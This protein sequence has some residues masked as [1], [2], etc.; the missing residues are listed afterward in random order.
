M[1]DLRARIII[2]A[3]DQSRAG[4]N[5]AR[6]GLDNLRQQA[7]Q[8][9][10]ALIGV[11]GIS[12]GAGLIKQLIDTADEFKNLQASIKLSTTSEQEFNQAQ[13]ELFNISQRTGT[14]LR[15]NVNLF[16]RVSAA[17][18]DMGG[19]QE[20]ALNLVE[21]IG[22]SVSL[23]QTSAE[24]AAA[25]V[26]QFNQGLASGV[27][28][29]EEFNSVMENT[30]RLAQAIAD[31]LQST[32]GELRDM[33]KEGKLTTDVVIKA[34]ESQADVLNREF[35]KLPDTIGRALVRVG[36]AWTFFLGKLDEGKGASA[37]IAG[38][39]NTV[40]EN[41]EQLVNASYV[42]VKV[43]ALVWAGKF[44]TGITQNTAAMINNAI[45]TREANAAALQLLQTEVRRA[46]VAV[47]SSLILVQ[48]AR[49]QRALATTVQQRVA[50][51]K[52][53]DAAYAKHE[54]NVAALQAQQ[55]LLNQTTRQGTLSMLLF[56]N[57]VGLVSRAFALLNRVFIAFLLIDIARTVYDWLNSFDEFRKTM[58]ILS[59]TVEHL[60][61]VLSY[62]L[63]GKIL[64]YWDEMNRKLDENAK[65]WG[66]Q[67]FA[68]GKSVDGTTQKVQ[69]AAEEHKAAW[70]KVEESIK[71]LTTLSDEQFARQNA[72]L[73]RHL[74]ERLAAID[75]SDA[76]EQEK[77]AQRAEALAQSAQ[78]EID[79]A[80]QTA[81]EKLAV[82]TLTY[83]KQ[84][85]KVAKSE[86]RQ[87]ALEQASIEK[88]K[89]IYSQLAQ[90]YAA[91]VDKLAQEHDREV[92]A[93]RAAAE[94]L[95]QLALNHEFE[96]NDIRRQGFDDY[97]K[98]ESE[99]AEF[100]ETLR[101]AEAEIHKGT[102]GDQEK[103]NGLL[104]RA[105][106]L[107]RD[108]GSTQ[109]SMA[110]SE[111]ER[112]NARYEAESRLNQ[113]Y[114]LQKIAVENVKKAH[115]DNADILARKQQEALDKLHQVNSEIDR[116]A[117]KLERQFQMQIHV[118]TTQVDAAIAKL[119]SIP[120]DKYVTIHTQTVS[121]GNVQAQQAGG[122]IQAFAAGGWPR[123]NGPIPG[124]GGGDKVK[125]LAEQGEFVVR[126]EGVKQLQAD[127]GPRAM[128]EINRGRLPI[129]R[130][131]GGPVGMFEFLRGAGGGSESY[132]TIAKVINWRFNIKQITEAQARLLDLSQKALQGAIENL[133]IDLNSLDFAPAF[134]SVATPKEVQRIN[135]QLQKLMQ[136]QITLLKSRKITLPAPSLPAF[137]APAKAGSGSSSAPVSDTVTLRFL[138]PSG[139]SVSGQFKKSDVEPML[140][141]LK[142]A[143]A[144]TA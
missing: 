106:E 120:T 90:H 57:A 63:S 59:A 31:G 70:G 87:R 60:M 103:I 74:A 32:T 92:Q 80:K 61:I 10:N 52:A 134:Q 67:Y 94:K 109:I 139:G 129:K 81:D 49:A 33:A 132:S 17:I 18:R 15:E 36:N 47:R 125:L 12:L 105:H 91:I 46:E 11:L 25:G 128:W 4:F 113:L 126:K 124:Y 131:G 143:G 29:G 44:V 65:K 135:E 34:V 50:A 73:Q 79:L 130:A 6:Q 118:D 99:K 138:A 9:R 16:R 48:E 38:A 141:V 71:S 77:D 101:K 53:L 13:A 72:D 39:L 7:N 1:A 85:E 5:N 51:Q 55:A 23:V 56:G 108:L 37:S 116:I 117:E 119:D 84:I 28:R 123:A 43:L 98:V 82:L 142:D 114:E 58:I 100:Q 115:E 19:D 127:Y 41:M 68:V 93:A 133:K 14:G 30:P 69:Q 89:E 75:A 42:L 112:S 88:R 21:L 122:P 24:S 95:K 97:A 54:A 104:E 2:T 96:L 121:D 83:D 136:S 3:D 137:A 64:A 35:A 26:Q 66:E 62:L 45:A 27:L 78:A 20:R 110:E 107:T 76:Q 144:V 40:A 140:R 102:A 22:K 86:E 8:V 111:G